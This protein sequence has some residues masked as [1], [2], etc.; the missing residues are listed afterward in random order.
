VAVEP[1]TEAVALF[2]AGRSSE[3]AALLEPACARD[4]DN[5]Q[6]WFLLGA[7]RHALRDLESAL[8]AFDRAIALDPANL[9]AA[10]AAIAVLCDAARP[11]EALARCED[12]LSRHPDDSQLQFSAGF[13]REALGDFAGAL[14]CYD[15]ALAL[16][17]GFVR[18]LQNRGIALTRLGR[19]HEALENNRKFVSLCPQDVDA[20]YNLTESCLAARLYDEAVSAARQAL[21]IDTGHSLSR[22]DLGLAL[23]AGGHLDE[24]REELRTAVSR[25]DPSVRRRMEQWAAESGAVDPID[26]AVVLEPEDIYLIMGCER[27][28][29]CEWDRLGAFT[30]RCTTMIQAA[31]PACLRTRALAFKFLH[32]PLP[33]SLQKTVADRIAEGVTRF[34]SALSKPARHP[35]AHRPRLRIGYMS[36]DFGRHPVGY[37][38]RSIYAL[39]D[40]ERFEVCGYA[41]AGD[42]GSENFRTIAD[43]CDKMMNARSLSLEQLASRIASDSIDI[44]VD[45]NG[46][47]RGGRS[48]VLALRPAP[49]QVAYVGYPATLGGMLADYFIADATAVPA[50][51]EAFFSEKIVRLPHSYA[52]ASHRSLTMSRTPG[53]REEGLPDVGFIFCAFHRHEKIDPAAFQSWMRILRAV[54]DSLLWLQQGPGEANLRRHARDAGID[55]ARLV[56]AAHR[57]HPEHLA[58]QQLADLFLDTRCWNAHT[59]ATDALWCGVPLVTLPGEHPVSRLGASLLRALGLDELIAKDA[60]EYETLAVD[61]ASHP[62]KRR[63]LKERLRSNRDTQPLFDVPRYVRNLERAYREMWRIH[64]SGASPR[65]FS[66]EET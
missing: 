22:L 66:I 9:Q 14:D 24:A 5:A 50:P 38:T 43:T 3:A 23:A 49:I 11:A 29:R 16:D 40:R 37:L 41:L 54:P 26:V 18:A 34:V 28:E 31:Q 35:R 63:E 59:T 58:R 64:E 32:L 62:D 6:A 12:L 47:T 55:P 27:L 52:P 7:C 39:H 17:P 56:F 57:D 19:I 10:Q 25:N 13:V 20:H 30:D 36:T 48:H 44:L 65:P 1:Y 33:A 4:P 46:Y 21:A 8:A 45:L 53:R 2:Q 42:D 15:R 61:L 60:A 51:A